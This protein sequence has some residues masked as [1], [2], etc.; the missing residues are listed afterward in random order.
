MSS[1]QPARP[2]TPGRPWLIDTPR[3]E[4]NIAPPGSTSAAEASAHALDSLARRLMSW[5][6]LPARA[7]RIA[8]TESRRTHRA[9]LALD[10]A[11]RKRGA[12]HAPATEEHRT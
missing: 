12:R 11:D 8:A 6:L 1:G 4:E 7:A 3:D 5:L 10:W 9:H 2:G